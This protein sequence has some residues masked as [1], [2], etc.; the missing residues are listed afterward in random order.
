MRNV[1]TELILMEIARG[2]KNLDGKTIDKQIKDAYG[3]M[4]SEIKQAEEARAFIQNAKDIQANFD[5]K[6]VELDNII[7]VKKEAND[8]ISI[9]KFE[10]A[11]LEKKRIDIEVVSSSLKKREETLEKERDSFVKWEEKLNQRESDIRGQEQ[12]LNAEREAIKHRAK[13]IAKLA[14]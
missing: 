2:L 12:S 9:M 4:E 6:Q 8:A 14:S 1:P 13:A 5:K 11:L 7:R 10:A 3:L